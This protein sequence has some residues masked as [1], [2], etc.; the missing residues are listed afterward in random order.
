MK[1]SSRGKD[2]ANDLSRSMKHQYAI[3]RRRN[4]YP[5]SRPNEHIKQYGHGQNSLK[6]RL[7]DFKASRKSKGI[8]DK[9]DGSSGALNK[10]SGLKKL[11]I[12]IQKKSLTE[13][14]YKCKPT[15][16]S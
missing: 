16:E 1:R 3:E 15:E 10:S 5:S 9:V 6:E 14:N 12:K 2:W 7:Q 4:G 8:W 13:K 11:N